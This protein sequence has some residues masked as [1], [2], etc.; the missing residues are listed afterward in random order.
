MTAA[1]STAASNPGREPGPGPP[2]LDLEVI[3]GGGN[4]EREQEGQEE[5]EHRDHEGQVAAGHGPPQVRRVPVEVEDGA[6]AQAR[7]GD[8]LEEIVAVVER[9]RRDAPGQIEE[10]VAE[11]GE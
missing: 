7:V 4:G 5:E 9:A 3:P 1:V 11:T 2:A 8:G 10:E 6:E